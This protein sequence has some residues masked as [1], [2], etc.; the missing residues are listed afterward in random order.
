M[1]K[2]NLK[3]VMARLQELQ[4]GIPGCVER[5]LDEGYWV[6][7]LRVVAEKTLRGQFAMV[8]DM[9]DRAR[10]ELYLPQILATLMMKASP[11]SRVF[12]MWLPAE[13]LSDVNLAAASKFAESQ[14]TP[15]GRARKAAMLDPESQPNLQAA[16]QAVLDWVMLEKEWDERDEGKTPEEIAERIETILGLRPAFRE[17]SQEM[18]EAAAGLRNAIKAW[19]EGAETTPSGNHAVQTPATDPTRNLQGRAT[20]LT[21]ALAR[22]WLEAVLQSWMIYF[23]VHLRDR[24]EAEFKKLHRKIQ[25]KQ[26]GLGL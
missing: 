5:A 6:P 2:S 25:G 19:L 10:Y 11:G 15:Q 12:E 20:G 26:P 18:D 8:A 14:W 21:N 13:S 16:R 24:V 22:Q 23:R 4:A 3:A 1:L 7:A 9:A 17:R